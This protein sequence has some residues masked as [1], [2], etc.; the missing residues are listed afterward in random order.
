[1]T[2]LHQKM[3]FVTQHTS[4]RHGSVKVLFESFPILV[5]DPDA[6]AK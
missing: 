2:I 5:F 3:H 4:L 6:V 1:M